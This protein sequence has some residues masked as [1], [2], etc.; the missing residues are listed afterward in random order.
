MTLDT[1]LPGC[2]V[3]IGLL[4]AV[5]GMPLHAGR[6]P[7]EMSLA[8]MSA[9]LPISNPRMNELARVTD[10]VAVTRPLLLLSTPESQ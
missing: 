5:G 10:P 7:D 4:L 6:D 3:L 9:P 2:I 1:A 8:A